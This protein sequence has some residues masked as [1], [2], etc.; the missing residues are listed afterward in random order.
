MGNCYTFTTKSKQ[1]KDKSLRDKN[2]E[3]QLE[4]VIQKNKQTSNNQEQSKSSNDG[5][6]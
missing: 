5:T 2:L 1:S 4:E 3:F 6:T